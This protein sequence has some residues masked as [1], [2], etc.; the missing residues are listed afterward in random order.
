MSDELSQEKQ[1][2]RTMGKFGKLMFVAFGLTLGYIVIKNIPDIAR[3]IKIS[4]M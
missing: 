3:Y 2:G 4:T 1:P